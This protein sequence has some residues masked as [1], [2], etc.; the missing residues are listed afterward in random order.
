MANTARITQS[1]LEVLTL[2]PGVARITQSVVETLVG[3]GISCASPPDGTVE[4]PYTYTFP[5][6]SGDPP[7]TF[8]I[9]AGELPLGLSLDP[10]TGI[11]SGTPTTAGD[12]P[13]TISV[14]D[15]MFSTAMCSIAI[16]IVIV[17]LGRLLIN[18][19]GAKI[20]SGQW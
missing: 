20:Y 19:I 2:Q 1:A 12:F 10:A 14:T 11:V 4:Q 16:A 5:V 8:S 15:S 7:Y 9:T 6:G 3:L 18:F 17:P 13:F